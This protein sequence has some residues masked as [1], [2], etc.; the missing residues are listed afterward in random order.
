MIQK[1][2]KELLNKQNDI[3]D[4]LQEK[5]NEIESSNDYKNIVKSNPR[6]IKVYI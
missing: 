1:Q 5:L 6:K 2:T 3:I 4:K